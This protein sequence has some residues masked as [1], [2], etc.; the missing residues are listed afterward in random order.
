MNESLTVSVL[1]AANSKLPS[2]LRTPEVKLR[3]LHQLEREQQLDQKLSRGQ[4]ATKHAAEEHAKQRPSARDMAM[5]SV[6]KLAAKKQNTV[7]ILRP[8]HV[9]LADK[10]HAAQTEVELKQTGDSKHEVKASASGTKKQVKV[11]DAAQITAEIKGD[12]KKLKAVEQGQES[13]DEAVRKEEVHKLASIK[14]IADKTRTFLDNNI[15]HLQGEEIQSEK[16]QLKA[17]MAKIEEQDKS[18]LSAIQQKIAGLPSQFAAVSSQAKG[19]A[20]S[21]DAQVHEQQAHVASA[22]GAEADHAQKSAKAVCND[23]DCDVNKEDA[24]WLSHKDSVNEFAKLAYESTHSSGKVR[25]EALAKMKSLEQSIKSD[26][27][28]VTSFAHAQEKDLA[29]PP[30]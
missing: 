29:P 19:A 25:E 22:G 4:L 8:M 30:K 14:A 26:F 28:H 9:Q 23:N 7:R 6:H 10:A 18:K 21:G 5:R 12:E 27:K 17:E 15:K 11:V 3:P 2:W 13:A 20:A 24:K 16:A 1:Q